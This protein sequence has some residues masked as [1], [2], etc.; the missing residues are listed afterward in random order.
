[1]L[2]PPLFY[3][4]RYP[5]MKYPIKLFLNEGSTQPLNAATFHTI[6]SGDTLIAL[7]DDGSRVS[8]SEAFQNDWKTET[9]ASYLGTPPPKQPGKE[10]KVRRRNMGRVEAKQYLARGV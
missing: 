4:F 3:H 10:S 6:S 1:M 7:D 9:Q 5:T 2:T 8:V